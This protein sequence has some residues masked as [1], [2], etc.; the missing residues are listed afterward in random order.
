MKS[1]IDSRI[2]SEIIVIDNNSSDNT[3]TLIKEQFK[4]VI[5][6]ETGQNLGFGKANNIGSRKA[7]RVRYCKSNAIF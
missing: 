5:L 3:T 7:P 2:K 6:V 1:V 4:N